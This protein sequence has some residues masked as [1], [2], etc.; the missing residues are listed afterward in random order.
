MRATEFLAAVGRFIAEHGDVCIKDVC[1]QVDEGG[2]E[3]EENDDYEPFLAERNR[4]REVRL[5]ALIGE[6]NERTS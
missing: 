6:A 3:I 5:E 1:L 2:I 4:R